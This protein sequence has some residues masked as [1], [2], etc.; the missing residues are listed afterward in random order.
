MN[1]LDFNIISQSMLSD[2]FCK[3]LKELD[4]DELKHINNF[5]NYESI[6]DRLIADNDE[7][8]PFIKWD[9]ISKMQAIRLV[10]RNLDLVKYINLKKYSYRIR[11]IFWFIKSDYTRLFEHFD[12]NI[13]NASHEDNYLLLCLGEKYFEERIQIEDF[14]FSVTECRDIIRAYKYRR[15]IIMRMNYADFKNYQVTEILSKTGE[16]NT[17]L[18]DLDILS[19]LNWIELLNYQ[20]DFIDRCDFDKFKNGDPFNLIQL[21]VLFETPDLSYLVF[22][23]DRDEISPFGWEKLLICNPE[24]YTDI[25][26]FRKF[27]EDNWNR[28]SVARP[29]LLAYKL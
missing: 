29:E 17:D 18:F 9:R 11:E 25:C 3:Y 14:K 12:F 26:D 1:E 20:P 7:L 22:E 24:K 10:S 4:S 23:I 5:I 27:S 2:Y 19:T 13:E 6:P 8:H 15:E 28:I 16:E 21:A